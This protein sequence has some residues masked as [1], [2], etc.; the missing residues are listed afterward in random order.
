MPSPFVDLMLQI[1]A[2]IAGPGALAAAGWAYRVYEDIHTKT[3]R[4]TEANWGSEDPHNPW[5]GTV[6]IVVDHEERMQQ[7]ED[8]LGLEPPEEYGGWSARFAMADGS[9]FHSLR[10]YARW[11]LYRLRCRLRRWWS[12]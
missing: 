8:E 11:K 9:G 5:P 1:S 6:K 7:I 2:A 10:G 4:N 3:D 12:E